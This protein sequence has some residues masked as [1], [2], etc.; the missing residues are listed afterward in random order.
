MGTSP[1][2]VD[3]VQSGQFSMVLLSDFGCRVDPDV[4]GITGSAYGGPLTGTS[5]KFIDFVHSG[6][7]SMVLLTDF[8]SRVDK[9]VW[10]TPGSTYGEIERLE[11]LVHSG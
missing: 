5:P 6:Q 7:F 2:L 8:G 3:L 10:G 1:K 4:W 9:E 11:D